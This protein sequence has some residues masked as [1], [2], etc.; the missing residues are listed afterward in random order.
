M[1][2]QSKLLV[3]ALL[4]IVGAS[5]YYYNKNQEIL[6][7]CDK[8]I[9]FVPAGSLVDKAYYQYRPYVGVGLGKDFKNKKEAFNYCKNQ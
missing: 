4:L 3:I 8:H 7:E 9:V 1:T 2:N 5:M 6:A